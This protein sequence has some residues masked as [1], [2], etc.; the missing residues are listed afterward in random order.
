M[1]LL[2][3]HGLPNVTIISQTKLDHTETVYNFEVQDFHTYHIGKYGVWVHNAECC[4][5]NQVVDKTKTLSP[6]ST[7]PSGRISGKLMDTHGGLVEKRKLSPQQQKMVDE[8]MKGD[9]G[10]EKTEKLTSSILKDSGYKELAG[11]KY[12]G[13]S[14]KGFDHVIQDTDGTVT[15]IDSKQLANSG[16]TKLGTSNA[17][18][19]LS[20]NAIRA[21]LPNLPINSPARK[22]IEKALDSGKL[23]TAVI[24][25]D[26]KTGNVLFTPFTVKP[27]K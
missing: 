18:V 13:G 25:V 15:I 4:E 10:G 19:Q 16:V 24:V 14:N 5:V 26:K 2:D 23:K 3:K 8:I 17:G 12:H 27:K 21:T 7:T 20:E 11:A 6:A 1:T 9:K 22:A